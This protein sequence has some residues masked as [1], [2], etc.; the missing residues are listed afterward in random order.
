MNDGITDVMHAIQ[1]MSPKRLLLLITLT[2][3]NCNSRIIFNRHN[4]VHCPGDCQV[5]VEVGEE[6]LVI[7]RVRWGFFF[8][9]SFLYIVSNM[10][11][12]SCLCVRHF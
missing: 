10:H 11:R 3:D 6:C 1:M 12:L 5:I 8:S 2:S 7:T 9:V 4:G